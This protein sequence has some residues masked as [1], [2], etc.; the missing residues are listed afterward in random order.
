M[1]VGTLGLRA[2]KPSSIMRRQ[3]SAAPGANRAAE[4][5]RHLR[6]HRRASQSG[7]GT[8]RGSGRPSQ[9]CRNRLAP[10]EFDFRAENC[11]TK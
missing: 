1:R 6:T 10:A 9:S 8:G 5:S 7:E 3:A 4:C 2:A 11:G